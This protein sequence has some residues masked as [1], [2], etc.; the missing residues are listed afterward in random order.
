MQKDTVTKQVL[1][2]IYRLG[3]GDGGGV[4]WVFFF[5]PLQKK[6]SIK[7]KKP[8]TFHWTYSFIL[9]E[10]SK[11]TEAIV[12]IFSS[13]FIA[14]WDGFHLN[15]YLYCQFIQL[16]F[17]HFCFKCHNFFSMTIGLYTTKMRNSLNQD[18]SQGMELNIMI[19]ISKNWCLIGIVIHLTGMP[20]GYLL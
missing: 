5:F 8:E 2:N 7:K 12:T 6:K 13:F 4:G 17:P 18:I 9:S 3:F 19:L 14:C 11:L 16:F 1:E 15:L 20:V 10:L